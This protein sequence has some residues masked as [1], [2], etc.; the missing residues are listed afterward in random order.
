MPTQLKYALGRIPSPDTERGLGHPL[1]LAS[2][3]IVEAAAVETPVVDQLDL[4]ACTGNSFGVG[5]QVEMSRALKLVGQY[6]EIP[7]R[8]FLYGLA[9]ALEGTYKQDAGA[10]ISDVAAGATRLGFPSESAWSYP[11]KNAT[12]EEQLAKCTA[13]MDPMVFHKAADQ[14][15]LK[16][17]YRLASTGQQLADDIARAIAMGSVVVWGTDLDQ[18]FQNLEGSQVWPGVQGEIIGGHAMLLRAFKR[19]PDHP[20]QRIYGSLSSWTED[21]ADRGT[22]WCSQDAVVNPLHASE[23]WVIGLVDNYSEVF[24]ANPP[25]LVAA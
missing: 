25:R 1:H 2:A 3:P 16:G 13:D 23:H 5:L 11:S 6:V 18:A 14:K 4:G 8:L 10:M 15:L 17:V 22:A 20:S 12:P 21:F 19:H 24:A 7:S 9:R